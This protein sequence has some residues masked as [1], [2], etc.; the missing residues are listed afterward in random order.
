M[1]SFLSSPTS[2]THS[3][4]LL[5]FSSAAERILVLSHLQGEGECYLY[6]YRA[7]AEPARLSS[8]CCCSL[9]AGWGAVVLW[10][11]L[12]P[13]RR[14]GAAAVRARQQESSNG[15]GALFPLM[16]NEVEREPAHTDRSLPP[17]SSA[18]APAK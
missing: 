9:T 13:S 17:R 4:P 11:L 12:G 8:L 15:A 14:A 6:R 1:A 2:P 16:W 18:V 3:T 10:V 5:L 7:A